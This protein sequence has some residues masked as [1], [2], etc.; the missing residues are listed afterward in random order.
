MTLSDLEM[1][2]S[3][4]CA[5]K[6]WDSMDSHQVLSLEDGAVDLGL[7]C[8]QLDAMLMESLCG[9][10]SWRKEQEEYVTHRD[11]VLDIVLQSRYR[12]IRNLLQDRLTNEEYLRIVQNQILVDIQGSDLLYQIFTCNILQRGMN[13]EAPFL[14]FIQRVCYTRDDGDNDGD[15]DDKDWSRSGSSSKTK[16][17]RPGC[18]G[19]GIRNFLTLFLSIEVSKAMQG[20]IEAKKHNNAAKQ[21]H[22]QTRVEYFTAQLNESNPILTEISNAMKEEGDLRQCLLTAA[23]HNP[24]EQQSIALRM[25]HAAER[26]H[27]GNLQLMAVSAKYND[28]MKALRMTP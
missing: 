20:V 9:S 18:G 13:D 27:N 1:V 11:K 15:N 10:D 16:M 23:Q 25:R 4:Q 24:Q 5:Q 19:F 8:T 12:N 22:E 2:V 21:K 3:S 26:K 14:E 6:I 28:I 17:M 7:T